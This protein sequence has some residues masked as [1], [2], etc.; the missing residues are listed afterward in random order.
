MFKLEG[1]VQYFKIGI[2]ASLLIFTEW[3][4]L[5]ISTLICGY[6]GVKEQSTQVLF[7][8]LLNMLNSSTKGLR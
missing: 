7:L 3:F 8:C 6:I 1:L 2:P 4:A 5:E